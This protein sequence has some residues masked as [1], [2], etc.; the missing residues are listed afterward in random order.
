[1]TG[2][3]Q[4][5]EVTIIHANSFILLFTRLRITN[6]ISC[7]QER[8][9]KLSGVQSGTSRGRYSLDLE[10]FSWENVVTFY[11]GCSFT[12]EE[13]LLRA[14]IPLGYVEKGR[15][16]AMY[17]SELGFHLAMWQCTGRVC[18]FTGWGPSTAA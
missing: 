12:F 14:G 9:F 11:L 13:S 5:P 2:E 6:Y 15:N 1:M 4:D 18:S 7:V 17:R 10:G 8:H 16:V 3:S